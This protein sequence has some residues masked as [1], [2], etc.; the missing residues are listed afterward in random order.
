[1]KRTRHSSLPPGRLLVVLIAVTALAVGSFGTATA[2]GLTT[3]TVRKIAA[4]VV[5]KKA[6]GLSVAHA[7]TATKADSAGKADTAKKA[8]SAADADKLGGQ[9][10]Q[11]YLDRLAFTTASHVSVP[12]DSVATLA[13]ATITVPT[14]AAAI[15]AIG[16]ASIPAALV[17]TTGLWLKLDPDVNGC[18]PM[19]GADYDRRSRAQGSTSLTTQYATPVQP[20]AHTVILCATVSTAA[21]FAEGI[22]LSVA[23][24]A[25]G[26]DGGGSL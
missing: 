3:K 8:D 12:G 10:P 21:V 14:G 25:R 13:T 4:K 26:R 7:A 16:V 5:T 17:N 19:S 22:S 9:S 6:P 1:M 24:V 20:G 2:A 11:L 15:S 23:S 18:N